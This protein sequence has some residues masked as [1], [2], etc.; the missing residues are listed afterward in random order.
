MNEYDL[1][2][3]ETNDLLEDL[4]NKNE[5]NLLAKFLEIEINSNERR[6]Y[7]KKYKRTIPLR[8]DKKYLRIEKYKNYEFTHCI[9]YEMAIRNENV[10]K[11]YKLRDILFIF[12]KN[13]YFSE[14]IRE[15]AENS[16][17]V[18]PFGNIT[19]IST[20]FSY[21]PRATYCI[22]NSINLQLLQEKYKE[23][24]P[25]KFFKQLLIEEKCNI[26]D[27]LIEKVDQELDEKYFVIDNETY[28]MNAIGTLELHEHTLKT[29]S[30]NTYKNDS[31]KTNNT[32]QQQQHYQT[33]QGKMTKNNKFNNNKSLPII[34]QPLR[35]L[36]SM[37]ISINLSLPIDD[38]LSFVKLIKDDYD[39]KNL[40]K[41]FF[42][43]AE[44]DLKFP[45]IKTSHYSKQKWADIFYIYDYFQF[46]LSE[47]NT[48]NKGYKTTDKKKR[49][50]DETS[51]AKEISLQL[52]YYH[53]LGHKRHLDFSQLADLNNHN[54]TYDKYEI[55][56]L[57]KIK[58]KIKENKEYS[59]Y[60]K[61]K[62][63]EEVIKFHISA[64]YIK[65]DYY[66]KMKEF[67]EGDNPEYKKFVCGKTHTK[68]SL[69]Q[70]RENN[71]SS[72]LC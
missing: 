47:K 7:L 1:T 55:D 70:K 21:M 42:E 56:L 72:K 14:F 53:I 28:K 18:E 46:Y 38:I 66:P 50:D 63:G 25:I 40:S 13:K 10:I 22:G 43:L 24:N 51:I 17:K 2:K 29:V 44:K 57:Y 6:K 71:T 19:T 68:K 49:E 15:K 36:D 16:I 32:Q 58:D 62:E 39:N 4:I 65:T 60:L 59:K 37:D 12:R 41:S 3:N 64:D 52:S 26:L 35:I 33:F 23:R 30:N 67:I 20:N 45:T 69:I 31:Y 9:T 54:S 34:S 11:L 61:D 5:S 48:I 8:A 27:W